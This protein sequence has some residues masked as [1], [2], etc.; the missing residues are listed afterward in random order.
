MMFMAAT[1]SLQLESVDIERKFGTPYESF[2]V[3]AQGLDK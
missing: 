1:K 3:T 2:V